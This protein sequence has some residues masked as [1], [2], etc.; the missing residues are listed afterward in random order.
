ML[1]I[2]CAFILYPV[3]SFLVTMLI[4]FLSVGD[5]IYMKV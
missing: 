5:K 4:Y 3:Y 2:K 1:D